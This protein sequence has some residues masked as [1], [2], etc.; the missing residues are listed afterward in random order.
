MN[1]PLKNYFIYFALILITIV[2]TLFLANNYLKDKENKSVLYGFVN[3]IKPEDFEQYVT[4]RPNVMIYISNIKSDNDKFEKKF[5]RKIESLN[6]V[7]DVVFI[8]K[9]NINYKFID[10][11]KSKYNLELRTNLDS[12]I[13]I[14]DNKVVNYIYI[15]D[16]VDLSSIDFSEFK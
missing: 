12:L 11:L 7:E 3:E 10:L 15:N 1:K 16:N 14:N 9:D 13:I 2:L 5:K 4:E 8:N 6:I